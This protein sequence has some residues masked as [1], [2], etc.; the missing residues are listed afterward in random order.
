LWTEPVLGIT[1]PIV[2]KELQHWACREQW[3][4]WREAT[5]FRQAK[6]LLRQVN[7]FFFKW[8]DQS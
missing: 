5:K 6:Q 7:N 8:M 3:R 2:L 1:P 4:Q